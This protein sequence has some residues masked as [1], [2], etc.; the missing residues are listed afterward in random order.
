MRR[1][2]FARVKFLSRLFT[3]LNLLPSIATV[4]LGEQ[5]QGATECNEPGADLADGAAIVLAEIRNRLVIGNKAAREPHHLDVAPGLT[6][7][8][9][10]RLNPIEVAVDVELQQHRRMIRRPAG[11]LRIDPVEPKLGQIKF[12]D[13]D[14]DYANGIV[15]ADPVFK[16]FRKQRALPTIRPLNEALHPILPQIVRESY[17]ANHVKRSV[18]THGVIP[19]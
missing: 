10:A 13:K 3:A 14:V 15:L 11:C 7:E 9:A 8:P 4:G 6:L 1:S 2:I 18:F 17:R 5:A 16:A 12:L 19:G